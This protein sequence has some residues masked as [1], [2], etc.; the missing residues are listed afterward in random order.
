MNSHHKTKKHK[1]SSTKYPGVTFASTWEVKVY[2][3][4]KDNGLEVECQPDCRFTYIVDGKVHIYQ[5]DF[6]INGKLYEVKGDHF[7]K[8]NDKGEE[9]M[10]HPYRGN[11]TD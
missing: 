7:F 11:L 1:F 2:E 4:C 3:F 5:P 10:F 6:L 8:I 9:I